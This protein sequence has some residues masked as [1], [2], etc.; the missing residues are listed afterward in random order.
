M[1]HRN[2]T[3]RLSGRRLDWPCR[4]VAGRPTKVTT[5]SVTP[6]SPKCLIAA[7]Q[8]SM[9]PGDRVRVDKAIVQY[10][11]RVFACL[12]PIYR[13]DELL[14]RDA[15]PAQHRRSDRWPFLPH[16]P[17]GRQHVPKGRLDDL[18]RLGATGTDHARYVLDNGRRR[19]PAGLHGALGQQF[20]GANSVAGGTS[21]LR[22]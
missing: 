16:C 3:P 17:I 7:R 10:I 20:E 5:S 15:T 8:S 11:C 2:F 19:R 22:S 13:G 9:L 1:R 18:A 12:D 21:C 6:I 14:L 4:R